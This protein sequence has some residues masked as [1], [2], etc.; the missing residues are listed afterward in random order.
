MCRKGVRE[1]ATYAQAHWLPA[2]LSHD[3]QTLNLRCAHIWSIALRLGLQ[4]RS[5]D[6]GLFGHITP[7]MNR[8]VSRASALAAP[9][10][11]SNVTGMPPAPPQPWSHSHAGPIRPSQIQSRIHPDLQPL[12]PLHRRQRRQKKLPLSVSSSRAR[13]SRLTAGLQSARHCL[14]R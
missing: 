9:S 2:H 1:L 12:Q 13:S 8:P 5:Y 14:R 3:T 11:T 4:L 10:P 7:K 6:N